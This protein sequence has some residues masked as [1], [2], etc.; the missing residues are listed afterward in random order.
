[1]KLFQTINFKTNYIKETR[2]QIT[3]NMHIKAHR[4]PE[5][6]LRNFQSSFYLLFWQNVGNLPFDVTFVHFMD[7]ILQIIFHS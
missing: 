6:I 7:V 2:K 5:K 1:M 4:S 3:R